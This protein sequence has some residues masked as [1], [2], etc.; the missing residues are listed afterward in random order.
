MTMRKLFKIIT[1]VIIVSIII[2]FIG[3]LQLGNNVA[4]SSNNINSEQASIEK[5]GNKGKFNEIINDSTEGTVEDNVIAESL[6]N[7]LS[8]ISENYNDYS[9]TSSNLKKEVID[10]IN[11]KREEAGVE[12]LKL[13]PVLTQMAQ[14]RA[15]ENALN[16]W[17][18]TDENGKHIRPDG[19]TAS[20]I[21]SDFAKGGHWGEIMG[22]FQDS[23]E[24]VINDWTNSEKHYNCMINPIYTKAGVGIAKDST[25]HYYWIVEF[26]E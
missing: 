15:D 24:E 16:D 3:L 7:V 25:N 14:I 4:K 23:P 5:Y 20:T 11:I 19:R 26:L 12:S 9:D 17:F 1:S 6:E 21:C 8:T 2:G 13:S 10:L 22:R 18:V